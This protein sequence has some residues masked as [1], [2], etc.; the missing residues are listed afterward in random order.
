M[1]FQDIFI[2]FYGKT[3]GI[4]LIN[5]LTALVSTT[6]TQ[7]AISARGFFWHYKPA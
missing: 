3:E 4:Q 6:R 1:L 7:N 5:E 2:L